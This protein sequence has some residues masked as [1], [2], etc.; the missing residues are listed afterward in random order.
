MML[1]RKKEPTGNLTGCNKFIG[2]QFFAWPPHRTAADKLRLVKQIKYLDYPTP[3]AL[4]L[5]R[6]SIP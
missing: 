3:K 4:L 1:I 6:F 5:T 2:I